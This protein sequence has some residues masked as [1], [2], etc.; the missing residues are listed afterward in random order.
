MVEMTVRILVSGAREVAVHIGLTVVDGPHTETRRCWR[1]SQQ[2]ERVRDVEHPQ[3]CR[4][5]SGPLAAPVGQDVAL[6]FSY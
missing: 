1:V 3:H 4:A 5:V 6:Q 2:R